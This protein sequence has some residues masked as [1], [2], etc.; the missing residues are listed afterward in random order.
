MKNTVLKLIIA[1]ALLIV[2]TGAYSQKKEK[3]SLKKVNVL[4]VYLVYDGL[5]T[6]T[7]Y[8]RIVREAFTR[9]KVK[10]IHK[11]EFEQ[12]NNNEVMRVTT[13]VKAPGSQYRSEWE[14]R[15]A[16]EKEQRF[17]TN[18]LVVTFVPKESG[19]SVVVGSATWSAI[20]FPPSINSPRASGDIETVLE[21]TC[22]SVQDNIFAIVEKI[23][24]SKWLR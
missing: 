16:I 23:L 8:T 2:Y 9:Y 20:P 22:C 24:F 11:L 19:D 10:L 15:E 4:P 21:D 5:P 12:F 7:S 18:M 17:V 13:K 6:D 1:S 3:S 14:I